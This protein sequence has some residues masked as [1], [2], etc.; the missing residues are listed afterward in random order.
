[1]TL[2]PRE[3]KAISII[4]PKKEEFLVKILLVM[5]PLRVIINVKAP[6]TFD[7]IAA[8]KYLAGIK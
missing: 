2:K 6:T 5:T 7:K 8:E 4:A 1:M 3:N